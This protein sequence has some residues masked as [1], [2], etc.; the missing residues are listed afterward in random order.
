MLDN[1]AITKYKISGNNR[2]TIIIFT[3]YYHVFI[4]SFT[5]DEYGEYPTN[6]DKNI[7]I[8]PYTRPNKTTPEKP[9]NDEEEDEEDEEDDVDDEEDDI[10]RRT[11]LIGETSKKKYST[12]KPKAPVQQVQ[13][14]PSA[15]PS[16]QKTKTS[17]PLSPVVVVH[18]TTSTSPPLKLTRRPSARPTI[19]VTTLSPIEEVVTAGDLVPVP[20]KTQN[21]L[22]KPATSNFITS[23]LM[24]TSMFGS[25]TLKPIDMP[26]AIPL[27]TAK[28]D[29]DISDDDD[30]KDDDHK[31]D[32]RDDD[33]TFHRVTLEE[34]VGDIKLTAADFAM[35]RRARSMKAPLNNATRDKFIQ[36]KL[37]R[38][39]EVPKIN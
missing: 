38:M 34:L 18:S 10:F 31:Y 14:A 28:D 21:R 3:Y 12:N 26:F 16:T 8:S 20:S 37:R 19:S 36:A 25:A 4:F 15:P 23:T 6:K 24:S 13:L 1:H 32:D 27:K 39:N 7:L 5:I 11:P 29:A 35:L 30:E 33:S 2:V 9:S 17:K 22:G